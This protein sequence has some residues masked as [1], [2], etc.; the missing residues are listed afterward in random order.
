MKLWGKDMNRNAIVYLVTALFFAVL[1]GWPVQPVEAKVWT[2]QQITNNNM[3]DYHP[4]IDGDEVVWVG[5]TDSGKW[6]T[7][8]RDLKA[9]T[10]VSLTDGKLTGHFGAPSISNGEVAI[11]SYDRSSTQNYYVYKDG[12]FQLIHSSPVGTY[13]PYWGYPPSYHSID[14]MVH[15]GEVVFSAWD[16]HD[17]EI[18]SW[19]DGVKKQITNND[20]DDYEPQV[21]NGKI[22]WTGVTTDPARLE[23]VFKYDSG[24]ITNIS[25]HKGKDE[26][27]Y[28]FKDKVVYTGRAYDYNDSLFD[29]Y[30]SDSKGNRH[31]KYMPGNDFEPAIWQNSV[32]WHNKVGNDPYKTYY[33]DG[34]KLDEMKAGSGDV[35]GPHVNGDRVVFRAFDGHDFEIY[36]AQYGLGSYAPKSYSGMV[37]DLVV[38]NNYAYVAHGTGGMKV[39]DVS[40]PNNLI[41][42]STLKMPGETFSMLQ[43]GST[44]YIASREAGVN[45]VDIANPLSPKLVSTAS[46]GGVATKLAMYGGYLYVGA[47]D[48]GLQ[49]L[50]VSQATAPKLVTS[51]SMPGTIFGMDFSQSYAYVAAYASGLNI[52]DVH[53]PN[54]PVF[55]ENVSNLGKVFDVTVNNNLA[56]LAVWGE[57]MKILDISSPLQPKLLSSL[58]VPDGSQG[59]GPPFKI[60]ISGKTA[61][62]GCGTE[63]LLA[64][65]ISDPLAPFIIER[66]DTPGFSW[67]VSISGT[68]LY[69]A[70][71][72]GGFK[73]YEASDHI[74]GKTATPAP[75]SFLL[76][77]SGAMMLA[78]VRKK[79]LFHSSAQ[80]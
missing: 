5:Y 62:L 33:Y 41:E 35:L 45:I 11:R 27:S 28:I 36:L 24:V 31:V 22:T 2:Y 61:F 79:G 3:D 51:V 44:L 49:V 30:I 48:A 19:K 50:D 69:A 53:A 47:K 75:A 39:F 13:E 26:D 80:A 67:G 14:P 17:Y 57:G 6:S 55:K 7:M 78:F 42:K 76:L 23:E 54:N 20:L 32:V 25:N 34:Y 43:K 18:F 16:G 1:V 65:D 74:A 15:N 4:A 9:T 37:R 40:D 29:I 8:Y 64:V 72:E 68:K 59:W 63:G 73:V 12:A 77:S 71:G 66:Y 21:Y 58:V 70:N 60:T 52:L 46:Y 56:Y 38:S 10:N